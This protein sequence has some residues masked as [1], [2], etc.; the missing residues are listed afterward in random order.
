MHSCSSFLR[1]ELP[2][3]SCLQFLRKEKSFL[4][5][6]RELSV[7]GVLSVMPT[8]LWRYELYD[9]L[10]IYFILHLF[11]KLAVAVLTCS[12]L[13][14]IEVVSPVHFSPYFLCD[15]RQVLSAS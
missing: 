8:R 15:P 2:W 4:V 7:S 11:E 10:A 1:G 13:Y 6:G 5:F 3:E 12:F 9:V 14:M